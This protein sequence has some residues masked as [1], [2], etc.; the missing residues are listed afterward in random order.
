MTE[1][2]SNMTALALIKESITK[3]D[4]KQNLG[5]I[6]PESL[7][8]KLVT[9]PNDLPMGD[10]G[11]IDALQLY[12]D[13]AIK[14][15]QPHFM[16]QLWSGYS[17]TG[18]LADYLTS[19]ANTSLYTYEVAPVAT[20]IE[21]KTIE[22]LGKLAGFNTPAGLFVPGSS[23]ANLQALVMARHKFDTQIKQAGQ[24]Q[25]LVIFAS[26]D[27]H[28]SLSKAANIMG[29]GQNNF[30]KV[31]CNVDG[32]MDM[33]ALETSILQAKAD[34]KSPFCVIG[35]AGTTVRG[36]IDPLEEIAKICTEYG[37]WLHVDGATG[38]SLLFSD[39]HKSLLKGIEKADSLA[40]SLHKM[41]GLPMHCAV[42][43]CQDGHHLYESVAVNTQDSD[44]LFHDDN[45]HDRGLLSLQC[46]R[47]PDVLKIWLDWVKHGTQGLRER[48]DHIVDLAIYAEEKIKR[49]P[50]F[51]LICPRQSVTVCFQ[52]NGS[53]P[54]TRNHH[55]K[56]IRDHLL[57][58]GK[59]AINYGWVQDQLALRIVPFNPD[60][61]KVHID[62]I[63]DMIATQGQIERK[64][65]A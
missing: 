15:N 20:L 38:A 49:S 54:Q 39:T 42:L 5:T 32:K 22:A 55:N 41:L 14:T 37:L 7:S 30:V 24:Q 21:E 29:F 18:A 52:H 43:L 27:A 10:Q 23:Y 50:D 51:D 46:G 28:Y 45:A 3:T 17:E 2:K 34:G 16:N 62:E 33:G 40:W 58:T 64:K 11:V 26:E 4:I 8:K 35:T 60:M 25:P 56:M 47:R 13:N 36:A 31:P 12:L 61:T 44:Y 57:E 9:Y 59:L 53:G 65:A 63:F 1:Y 6:D 48:V 19:I